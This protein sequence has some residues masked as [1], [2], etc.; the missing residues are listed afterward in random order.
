[1]PPLRLFSRIMSSLLRLLLRIVGLMLA[2]ILVL[3]LV[4][5]LFFWILLRL[6]TGRKPNMDVSA[7]F[8]RV[9]IFTHLGGT[10]GRAS[11]DPPSEGAAS[12]SRASL[13][14]IGRPPEIQDVHARDLPSDRK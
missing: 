3:I 8:S 12:P 13:G 5:I 9:R 1:M 14:S 10:A 7:H 11:G 6:L 2:L 4:V